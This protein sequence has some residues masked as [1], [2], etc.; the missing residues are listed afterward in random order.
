MDAMAVYH[1]MHQA[2]EDARAGHGP[3]L[4]DLNVYRYGPHSSS[5]DD[6]YYRSR[7]EVEAWKARDPLPRMRAWLESRKLWD[8]QRDTA[9]YE[10]TTQCLADTADRVLAGDAP[11]ADWMF[12][13]VFA[14]MPWHLREQRDLVRAE[15]AAEGQ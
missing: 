3:S 9:L 4:V 1:V 8:A 15:Q 14:D 13:D 10:R 5:D 2:I 6:S 11:P 12:D 7:E